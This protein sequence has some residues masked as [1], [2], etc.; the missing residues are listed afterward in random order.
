MQLTKIILSLTLLISQQSLADIASNECSVSVSKLPPFY[1]TSVTNIQFE[2]FDF[3]QKSLQ[4]VFSKDSKHITTEVLRSVKDSKRIQNKI[5]KDTLVRLAGTSNPKSLYTQIEVLTP[6]IIYSRMKKLSEQKQFVKT[7]DI[8]L[9]HKLSLQPIDHTYALIADQDIQTSFDQTV[10][11]GTIATPLMIEADKTNPLFQTL[12]CGDKTYYKFYVYNPSQ[13]YEAIYLD[14]TVD[15]PGFSPI[16]QKH[17][18]GLFEVQKAVQKLYQVNLNPADIEMDYRGF[19]RLPKTNEVDSHG[20]SGFAYDQSFVHYQGGDPWK[21]DTWG[22]PNTII[23]LMTLAQEWSKICKEEGCTLQIGDIAFA[24]GA[25]N[26]QSAKRGGK[27][28]AL[29]HATH[30]DGTCVDLRA[31]RKDDELTGVVVSNNRKSAYNRKRTQS[32]IEFAQ[33][34]GV[35]RVIYG[36]RKITRVLEDVELDSGHRDHIHICF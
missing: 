15:G 3:L 6:E 17:L 31:F 20:I 7:G 12:V 22:T 28:D 4:K 18:D 34:F 36:D 33:K 1:S 16:Y 23:Q 30:I 10:Q 19:I 27:K 25:L 11:R 2:T 32:F 5:S 26:Y 35:T 9:I 14:P 29:M 21:S 8:G 13:Q 24:T